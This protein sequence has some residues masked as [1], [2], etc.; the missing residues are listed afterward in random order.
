MKHPLLL[1]WLVR[2]S[3]LPAHPMRWVPVRSRS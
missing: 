1:V 3:E 2:V